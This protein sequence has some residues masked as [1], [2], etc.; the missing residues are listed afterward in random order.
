MKR[1]DFFKMSTP[2]LSA[3]FFLNSTMAS[4]FN[5]FD[6][7]NALDCDTVRDRFLVMVQLR[8]ANDGL[9]TIIRPEFDAEYAAQRSSVYL[10]PASLLSSTE[11]AYN[12]IKFHPSMNKIRNLANN[13]QLNVVQSVGYPTMNRSHFAATDIWLTGGDGTTQALQEGWMGRYL[14]YIFDGYNGVP[15]PFMPD[16]L[17]I[18]L[19]ATS[20]SLGFHTQSEHLKAINLSVKDNGYYTLL[21]EYGTSPQFFENLNCNDRADFMKQLDINSATYGAR[22][23]DKFNAGS[24]S[25]VDYGNYDLGAQLKTVARLVNGGSRTKIFLTEMTGFDTHVN[26]LGKHATLMEHLSES[27]GNFTEDLENLGLLDRCLIVTFSE[28]G[29]KF[30]DNGT[31]MGTD[32]GTLA[33]MMVFGGQGKINA[34]LTGPKINVTTLDNQGAPVVTP[35]NNIDYREVFISIMKQWLGAN[36]NAVDEGFSVYNGPGNVVDLIPAAANA[37][38]NQ[39]TP[40]CYTTPA[41]YEQE[42]SIVVPIIGGGGNNEPLQEITACDYVDLLPGF[43]APCGS[44]VIVYPLVCPPDGEYPVDCFTVPNDTSLAVFTPDRL[45]DV[46]TVPVVY[47]RKD[48]KMTETSLLEKTEDREQVK[49]NMFPNP[50]TDILN[51]NFNLRAGENKI[52]LE[53]LDSSGRIVPVNLPGIQQAASR[54]E[55]QINVGNLTSGTYYLRYS[56]EQM[57]ETFKFVKI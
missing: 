44:N 37:T 24:N 40:L 15:S 4:T 30:I 53:V 32:H 12:G 56:S 19:K 54:Y 34:G 17:G 36:E 11:S 43:Q 27:I 26:Q 18:H 51:I 21:S 42:F 38:P 14:E 7:F 55:V 49:I 1:R 39:G 25:S 16:P 23:L 5:S 41:E 50:T 48:V 57:V 29:R 52:R 45:D 46:I 47:T 28:F 8:G 13:G 3:P 31:N 33:P 10:D 9:N 35:T 22:V 6:L 2:M 20:P